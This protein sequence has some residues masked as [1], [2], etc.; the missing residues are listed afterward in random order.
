[1]I[2]IIMIQIISFVLFVQMIQIVTIQIN[3]FKNRRIKY[4][5]RPIDIEIENRHCYQR[6]TGEKDKLRVWA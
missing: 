4:R 1:M 6:G 5:N 3:L 2:Q